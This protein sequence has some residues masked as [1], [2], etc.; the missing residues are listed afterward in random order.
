MLKKLKTILYAEISDWVI[1]V[2]CFIFGFWLV[3]DLFVSDMSL[4]GRSFFESMRVIYQK[5]P[6]LIAAIYLF[7]KP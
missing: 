5:F 2:G 6:L 1:F 7:S 3:S 4:H